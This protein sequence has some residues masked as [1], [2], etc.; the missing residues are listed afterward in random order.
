[1]T[2]ETLSAAQRL[3]LDRMGVRYSLPLRVDNREL[4]AALGEVE[5]QHSEERSDMQEARAIAR[6]LAGKQARPVAPASLPPVLGHIRAALLAIAV[7][8][9]VIA[10]LVGRGHAQVDVIRL[11]DNAGNPVGTIAAPFTWKAGANCN[12]TK[13][14][15]LV[16]FNCPAG[17]G[18]FP[19]TM[20]AVAHKW[21]KSYDAGTGLF[22]QTQPDY[23]DL[24]SLPTLPAT[25]ANVAHK[26]LN[27]YDAGTGLFTQTQPACGDLSDA[28]SGCGA[29]AG[30]PTTR[31]V[32]TSA[33][34]SGGGDLSADRTL[35]CPTCVTAA[36]F[37]V[38]AFCGGTV[39]NGNGTWYVIHPTPNTG[40]NDSCAAPT[41]NTATPT[42]PIAG[43]AARL[44]AS[45]QTACT[46]G[47]DVTLFTG[48]TVGALSASTLTV[49]MGTTAAGTAVCDTTH[50]VSMAQ[51][52]FWTVEIRPKQATETCK[53]VAV[54]FKVTP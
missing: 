2:Y 35:S 25:L 53:N 48:A 51:D 24:T 33:P 9:L 6:V 41:T 3:Y 1:M 49:N 43:T 52:V 14:A 16:T 8:L 22:T 21:L 29:A 17:G 54:S 11:Q 42:M 26:W 15:S 32:N 40:G 27:S 19:Q 31:N 34:L 37:P 10:F 18:T 20:T 50:T 39:G 38:F 36:P 12:F 44:C 45:V 30:V 23:T 7:L 47:L 46:T 4:V 28:G 13:T 5:R